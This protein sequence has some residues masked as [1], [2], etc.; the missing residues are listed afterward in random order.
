MFYGSEESQ[1]DENKLIAFANTENEIFI[2]LTND[3][4]VEVFTCLDLDTAV[5]FSKELRRQ[6]SLIK[7]VQNEQ[8]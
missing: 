3:N 4:L 8:A 2:S 6:I 1:T 5:Q 7:E